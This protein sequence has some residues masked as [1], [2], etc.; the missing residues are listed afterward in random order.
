MNE[1]V[2]KQQM[3]DSLSAKLRAAVVADARN[4]DEQLLL[5]CKLLSETVPYYNWVGFYLLDRSRAGE[6]VLGP[7]VGAPTEHKR[8]PFGRGLCGQTA[9][10]KETVIA[11]DVAKELNYLACSPQIKSEIVV[12]ILKR[13]ELI[14]VLDIDSHARSAFTTEDRAFLEQVCALVSEL[15]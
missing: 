12:P 2:A 11:Q 13:G 14:G 4:T 8:I 10:Q 9:E 1:T 3:L 15:C 6:L 7:F 5:I